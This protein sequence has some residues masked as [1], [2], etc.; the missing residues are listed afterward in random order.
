MS[1]QDVSVLSRPV[2]R[3][4]IQ[5]GRPFDQ[6]RKQWE[7]AVPAWSWGTA[8]AEAKGGGGWPALENLSNR[9]AGDGLVNIST[10]DPGPVM[11]LAGHELRAVTYLADNLVIE[12][13]LYKHDPAIIEYLP[14]RLT[15]SEQPDGDSTLTFDKPCDL[16]GGY[17]IADLVEHGTQVEEAI[18][19]VLRKVNL[20]VPPE[21]TKP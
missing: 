16:F 8:V 14:V 6:F 18:A 4:V 13:G 3:F 20:P 5:T 10:F 9:S 7:R 11:R 12:E 1:E 15:I 17:A 2:R 19:T 21:L